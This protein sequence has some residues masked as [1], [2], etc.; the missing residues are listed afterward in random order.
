MVSTPTADDADPY[1]ADYFLSD[2]KEARIRANAP[3]PCRVCKKLLVKQ[4]P[5]LDAVVTGCEI[6]G[7][8]PLAEIVGKLAMRLAESGRCDFMTP[9]PLLPKGKRRA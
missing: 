5:I 1:A 6:G 4:S 7:E 9:L 3:V 8:A 2:D